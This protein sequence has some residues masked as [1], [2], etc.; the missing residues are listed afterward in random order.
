MATS[1]NAQM[2][3]SEDSYKIQFETNNY[4]DFKM[5]EKACRKA[6]DNNIKA[7]QKER[8]SQMSAVGHL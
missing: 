8:A 2:C 4:E 7:V 3:R 1:Y 6:V 5:V